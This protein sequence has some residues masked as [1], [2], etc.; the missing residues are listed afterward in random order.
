[1]RAFRSATGTLCV[2]LLFLLAGDR[3]A[4][5]Q[6]YSADKPMGSSAQQLPGYL[7]HAGVEQRLGQSLPL[8]AAYTDESGHTAALSTFFTG[9]PVALA[10]VY[11][12]CAMLCP[13]VL[14][15]LASGLRQTTLQ[16]G[17]DYDV[18]VF[19]ISPTDTPADAAMGKNDFLK[20]LGAGSAAGSSV[21][22]LTGKQ[23]SIDAISAAT[24]FHYVLVP[25]PDGKLDQYAHSSVVMFA[26]P[27]GR[28]SKYLSGID[29]PPRDLRLAL[30]GAS[31]HKIS[32]PVDLLILY[33]C[34]YNPVVGKYSV[35]ILRVLGIAGMIAIGLMVGMLV[36]LTR[37][38]RLA[39]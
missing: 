29:Y 19:S 17:K 34:S 10:L 32:N 38:P 35:S 15:G 12:R 37:K 5:A 13:Q 30:L 7:A 33:C 22:F 1:M 14:H 20:E 31:A 16:T 23:P 25:G 11:Y 24:G 9:K 4:R 6:G 27:E 18:L 21:H 26:T 36:V 28:L 39:R 8:S 3:K 2:F